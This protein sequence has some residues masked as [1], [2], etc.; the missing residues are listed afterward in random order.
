MIHLTQNHLVEAERSKPPPPRSVWPSSSSFTSQ[1]L[2]ERFVTVI[3]AISS[4]SDFHELN[5]IWKLQ[6]LDIALSCIIMCLPSIS[7]LFMV[8]FHLGW[9]PSPARVKTS[10]RQAHV[11]AVHAPPPEWSVIRSVRRR[12]ETRLWC[13]PVK[14]GEGKTKVTAGGGKTAESL[15]RALQTP[16]RAS[17]DPRLDKNLRERWKM[18]LSTGAK[19]SASWSEIIFNAFA[20]SL[21]F[22]FLYSPFVLLPA[23]PQPQDQTSLVASC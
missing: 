23:P 3:T 16:P 19:P 4:S 17:D 21:S 8:L 22:F 7:L 15:S 18:P 20:L 1:M 14:C 5:D 12:D 13:Q 9:S 10:P 11:S 6:N 2:T